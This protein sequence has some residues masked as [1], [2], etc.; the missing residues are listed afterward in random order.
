MTTKSKNRMNINKSSKGGILFGLLCILLFY[1]P[2][3]RGLFFEKELLP[4]HIFSFLLATIW[5]YTKIKSDEKILRSIPDLLG[6]CIVG[7][8]FISI[9]YGV[10]TRLAIGE[11]LKY[12]NYYI[13]YLLVR[14]FTQDHEKNKRTILHVLLGSGAI[15]AIIGLGSAIGIFDYNGAFVDGRINSTF[16]YPNALASYLFAL[17]ILSLGL[18]QNSENVKEKLIYGV[19]AN[20]FIFTF[21]P[22][23]SR[24]MWVLAPIISMLYFVIVPMNKKLETILYSM[25]TVIPAVVFSAIF[26]NKMENSNVFIQWGLV[27]VS[28]GAT[29]GLIIFIEKYMDKLSNIS[30]RKIGMSIGILFLLGVVLGGI[31]L[32]TTE[33]LVLSNMDSTEDKWQVTNREIL[34]IDKTKEY[35]LEVNTKV[36]NE[37]GKPYAARVDI[38]SVDE[39]GK[40]ETL[41]TENVLE[42]SKLEIPF[43][44]IDTTEKIKTQF[45]NYYEGTEVTFDKAIIYEKNSGRKIQELKLKYKFI[46][47]SFVTRINSITTSDHSLNARTSFYKDAFKIIR[48]YPLFGAGGGGWETLYFTYQS[49][50]YWSTQA[51]NYFV[52]LWI[53]IGTIGLLVYIGLVTTLLYSLY[54][55]IKNTEEKSSILQRAICTGWLTLLIHSVMDFDLS[56]GAM[57]IVLWTLYGLTDQIDINIKGE[58]IARPFKYVSIFTCIVLAIGASSLQ[59]A[60]QN[61]MKGVVYAQNS[62]ILESME[63]FEKATK[64]DPFSSSNHIDLATIYKVVASQDPSYKEKA[65]KSMDKAIKVDQYNAKILKKVGQMYLEM[66]EFE[67]G[68]NLMDQEV[69][70][71]P[72]NIDV[73]A[74]QTTAYLEV[75][76]YFTNK[77]DKA[78]ID[79]ITQKFENIKAAFNKNMNKSLEPFKQ[80]GYLN[81]NFQKMNYVLDYKDDME[82]LKK[83][84]QIV[85]YNKFDLDLDKNG[86]PD[87][88]GIWNAEGGNVKVRKE[89]DYLEITN[90]GD[91]YGLLLT[92]NLTLTPEKKY[93]LEIEYSSNLEERGFDVI[94]G[95]LSEKSRIIGAF[96]NVKSSKD[97]QKLEIDF[98]VPKD[99]VKEK[100][101]VYIIHR[102]NDAGSI[103]VR[104]MKLMELTD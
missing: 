53:E 47:E 8:Y 15:V 82:K 90:N 52:Q 5:L 44:T 74:D 100:Q 68:L 41:A 31:A 81:E 32:H 49:Y 10:N 61:A 78:W 84:E 22:T 69:K 92:E 30:F 70:V 104:R 2:F 3:F 79:K 28:I 39:E 93:K 59:F 103:K 83:I 1:P 85:I 29:I 35:I 50:M 55:T 26:S 25:L 98:V 36:K 17:F 97:F 80:N 11:F 45:S 65:I 66:G 23:F 33:P 48:D 94:I 57:S 40:L 34:D 13:I 20:L 91:N 37:E 72:M 96:N 87:G 60:K 56:L 63:Y 18:L 102:E 76:K 46:P 21:I 12:A 75:C 86:V 99:V 64:L 67:K 19:L 58:N 89:S 62:R 54:K 24:G 9:F 42:S 27:F 7:M 71:Q 73:Y 43:K 4:T 51:H 101:R 16:Q 77:N 6:L 95:D 38:Y 14:D 88:T